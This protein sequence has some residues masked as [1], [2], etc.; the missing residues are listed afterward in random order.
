[1]AALRQ[2]VGPWAKAYDVNLNYRT[3]VVWVLPD[4]TP[5][6]QKLELLRAELRYAA[7]PQPY[8][9][10]LLTDYYYSIS[11]FTPPY[12]TSPPPQRA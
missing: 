2:A 4:G 8:T 6:E 1:M 5:H 3:W 10:P 7:T 12:H 11:I 9:C